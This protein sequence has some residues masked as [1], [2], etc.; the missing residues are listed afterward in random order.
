[1]RIFGSISEKYNADAICNLVVNILSN[2]K[3]V[4]TLTGQEAVYRGII[5]EIN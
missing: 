5:P 4:R 3:T 1:M 2:N